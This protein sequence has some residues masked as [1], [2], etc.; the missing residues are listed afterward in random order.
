MKGMAR[1]KQKLQKL[2]LAFV[3]NGKRH[4]KKSCSQDLAFLLFYQ[5]FNIFIVVRLFVIVFGFA[6][7]RFLQHDQQVLAPFECAISLNKWIKM[8]TLFFLLRFTKDLSEIVNTTPFSLSLLRY[9]K[10]L[11]T[12]QLS[13]ENLWHIV[14]L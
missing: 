8:F 7:A 9:E 14:C 1:E 3:C 12:S 2:E 5:L 6:A 10:R 11:A 4:F 13:F